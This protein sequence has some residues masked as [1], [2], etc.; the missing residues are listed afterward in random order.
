MSGTDRA[1]IHE[2]Y[3]GGGESVDYYEIT[4]NS[5]SEIPN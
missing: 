4:P 1:N 5:S 3:Q 2:T